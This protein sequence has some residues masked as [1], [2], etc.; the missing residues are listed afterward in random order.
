MLV[1]QED[2]GAAVLFFAIFLGMLYIATGRP[3][4]VFFG[5]LLF[6]AGAFVAYG[7]FSHV[8]GRVA[9]WLNP[10]PEAS[11]RGYQTIQA[12]LALAAG[13][14]FGVGLGY[15]H[16]GLIPAVHTDLALAALGEETGLAVTAAIVAVYV[17]LVA[18]G[19]HIARRTTDSFNA[20]LAAGLSL[21]VGVQTLLII[22][23]TLRLLPLTGITLPFLSYGGSSLVTNYLI[24][25]LLLRVSMERQT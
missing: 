2:L 21:A 11:G 18:R 6:V 10:W 9:V 22:G 14:V 5:M 24:I 13:G 19:L 15:G 7:L 12:I 8:Q 25:G 17:V 23:G 1:L 4:Y 3:S 16:P 20:L